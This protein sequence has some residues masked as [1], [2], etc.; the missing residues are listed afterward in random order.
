[1]S[2][3]RDV[4]RKIRKIPPVTRPSR[5]DEVCAEFGGMYR[6]RF[7]GFSYSFVLI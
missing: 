2:T 1:M 7:S 6:C 4:S 5:T 3:S